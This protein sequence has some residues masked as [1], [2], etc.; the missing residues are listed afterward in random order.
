[1]IYQFSEKNL[2]SSRMMRLE[3]CWT[4]WNSLLI[5]RWFFFFSAY[6]WVSYVE[7]HQIA[8]LT[9]IMN[10][11][12]SLMNSRSIYADSLISIN[13]I[14]HY[15][16]IFVGE[17]ILSPLSYDQNIPVNCVLRYLVVSG[18]FSSSVVFLH[19]TFS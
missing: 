19:S 13:F 15:T 10:F 1:M 11:S 2:V 16:G 14:Y 7:R 3:K 8:F 17:Y 18:L 6:N 5:V 12:S 9:T 4:L